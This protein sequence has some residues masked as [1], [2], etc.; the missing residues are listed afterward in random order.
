M[1]EHGGPFLE[2]FAAILAENALNHKFEE[3]MKFGSD[4]DH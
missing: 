2:R 3:I 4:K 1:P